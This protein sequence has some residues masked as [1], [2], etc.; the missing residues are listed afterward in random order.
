MLGRGEQCIAKTLQEG[1]GRMRTRGGE[2][3]QASVGSCLG[4]GG[5]RLRTCPTAHTGD[6]RVRYKANRDAHD[7]FISENMNEI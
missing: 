3:H 5:M 1:P 2:E 6:C 7:P 4:W